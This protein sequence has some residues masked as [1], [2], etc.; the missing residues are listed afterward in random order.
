MAKKP[1]KPAKLTEHQL[2]EILT[3]AAATSVRAAS[4]QFHIAERS[5]F[6]YRKAL[7]DGKLPKV[8]DLVRRLQAGAMDRCKDLLAEVYELALTTLKKKIPDASYRELLD[9]VV[10]TGGLKTIR[11]G[12]Q[13]EGGEGSGPAPAGKTNQAAGPDPPGGAG[14]SKTLRV[15]NGA[16]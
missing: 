14:V 8:A 5:I 1:T 10:E 11:D 7:A 4:A 3:H 12:L 9:T 15:V 6:R 16:G 13:D 2:A